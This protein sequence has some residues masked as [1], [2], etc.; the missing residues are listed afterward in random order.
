MRFCSAIGRRPEAAAT[1]SGCLAD[2]RLRD[3]FLLAVRREW[4]A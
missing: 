1:L 2:C 4:E 3:I